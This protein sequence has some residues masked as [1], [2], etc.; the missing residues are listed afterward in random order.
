M[1]S[2]KFGEIAKLKDAP[3]SVKGEGSFSE[4]AYYHTGRWS[5]SVRPWWAG[6][7]LKAKDSSAVKDSTK[8]SSDGKKDEK[9]KSDDPGIRVLKWYDAIGG[10]DISVPWTKFNHPDFPNQEVEIG[11]VKPFVLTNPPADSLNNYSKPFSNFI[12][13]LAGE[14]ADISLSNKKV[15]KIGENVFRISIDVINNGYLPTN[16]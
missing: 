13:Y 11:G 15:E 16:G 4:W 3:K 6:E 7:I 1:I 14:L 9:D 5:F 12:T 2:K 10:K 8:K